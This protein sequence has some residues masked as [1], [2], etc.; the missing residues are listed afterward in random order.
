[1]HLEFHSQRTTDP[2]ASVRLAAVLDR[3][4]G[5]QNNGLFILSHLCPPSASLHGY[6][7]VWWNLIL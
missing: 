2:S 4:V 7:T 5:Q 3:S 6:A 1:M